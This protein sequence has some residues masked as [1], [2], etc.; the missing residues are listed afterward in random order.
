MKSSIAQFFRSAILQ[1][2][3]VE[4]YMSDRNILEY[5]LRKKFRQLDIQ[6]IQ[7]LDIAIGQNIF[8]TWYLLNGESSINDPIFESLIWNVTEHLDKS[9]MYELMALFDQQPKIHGDDQKDYVIMPL[10]TFGAGPME[11]CKL[12]ET[13]SSFEQTKCYTFNS[14]SSNELKGEKVGPDNGLRF[15][16]KHR[17]PSP[18]RCQSYICRLRVINPL[19]LILHEPGT[20]PDIHFR[21]NTYFEIKPGKQYMIGTE[22]TM[23]E[24]TE[25]FKLLGEHQRNCTLESDPPNQLLLSSFDQLWD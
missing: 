11:S 21:T 9:Q 5:F 10:C 3:V 23:L 14:N 12:F 16:T 17:I 20:K 4:D 18:F 8:R 19:K 15:V 1:M 25:S 2:L 22:A 6:Y 24:V 13:L 7:D